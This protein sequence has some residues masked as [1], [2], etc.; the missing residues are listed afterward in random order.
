MHPRSGDVGEQ[1]MPTQSPRP[2]SIRGLTESEAQ[3]RLRAEGANELPRPDRRT[4]LRIVLEVLREPVLALLLGGGTIYLPERTWVGGK[5]W[6]C[7]S[8][9]IWRYDDMTLDLGQGRVA[10]TA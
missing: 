4:P 10:P 5:V 3:A 9:A 2:E 6:P 7:L 8:Y 1:P